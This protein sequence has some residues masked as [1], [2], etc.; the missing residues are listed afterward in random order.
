LKLGNSE[1]V[2]PFLNWDKNYRC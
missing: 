1:F 2:T